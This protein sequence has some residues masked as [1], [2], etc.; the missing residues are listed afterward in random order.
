MVLFY[1]G[2]FPLMEAAEAMRLKTTWGERADI[3]EKIF[4]GRVVDLKSEWNQ[5]KTLIYTLVKI[6]VDEYIKGEG[7]NEV[8]LKVPG[9]TVEGQTHVVSDTPQF[10]QDNNYV[11]FLESS[12]QVTGGPDG[13][14]L[15]KGEKGEEFLVWLRAYLSD[16][17]NA[18][19]EGPMIKPMLQQ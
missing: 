1:L 18:T 11:V 3:S 16:D 9:G 13:I 7:L 8:V 17:P 4:R 19:K 10:S 6:R 2:C 15:L 12:G 14:Y 5:E